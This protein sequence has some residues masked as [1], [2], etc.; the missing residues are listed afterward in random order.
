[1]LIVATA[2][3]SKGVQEATHVQVATQSAFTSKINWLQVVAALVTCT[4]AVITAFNLPAD[5]AAGITAG[6]AAVGQ[7]LTLILR[8]FYTTSIV[9][10]SVN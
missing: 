4:T 1:M 2:A 6:V 9:Q 7:V 10:N 5:Q 3:N 8:T